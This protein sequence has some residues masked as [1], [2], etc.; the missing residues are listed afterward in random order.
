M[1][2]RKLGL[3][4]TTAAALAALPVVA[5]EANAPLGL[6]AGEMT[7]F[8]HVDPAIRKA[9]AIVNGEVITDTDV[10][11]RLQLVLTANQGRVSDEERTRLRL[12]IV[13][14]LID[15]KLQ[16]QEAKD[17]DVTITDAEVDQAFARVGQNFRQSPDRLAE[18]LKQIGSSAA[19]LRQQIRAEL[20]WSRLLRRRVEPFVNVGDDEVKAVI[21]K[22]E[23][24]KGQDQY[25]VGEI[26]LP[27]TSE[28]EAQVTA[29]AAR[30]VQQ[31]RA[32]ASF[33][34]YARQF[35]EAST[36][37]VGGDLGYVQ[38][39][40]L[41]APLQ[42]V[43]AGLSSGQVSDPVRVPGGVTILALIDKRKVLAADPN[44]AILSLKQIALPFKPGTTQAQAAE[45]VKAMQARTQSMGGCGRAEEVGKAMGA[46]V[47]AN[48]QIRLRDLPPQLQSLMKTMQVGQATPP[49][50]SVQEGIRVLV[51][52][53]R[54]DAPQVK[55]PSFDEVYAQ[56]N[57]E[58][59]S[60]AA[61]R[62]MR[63]LRRDAIVDYR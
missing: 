18:Y 11:Q 58:R 9:T 50:G 17:H 19:S 20:A 21:D 13:R 39:E 60:R 22:L 34:A 4:L 28:N 12:Q 41:A 14:N 33:V 47:V 37:A 31:V 23:A 6:G 7:L 26:F 24:S 3:M 25:R 8:G 1:C 48:D 44:D 62:Y 52:C 2:L 57:E 40:Q 16:I 51:L 29:D 53:G 55:G 38:P 43:L 54:D 35:S 49:F 30:I 5:Q 27:A 61:R 36:A 56:L 46:E 15:E 45:A 59:V 10:D 42:P 32:G 63:D